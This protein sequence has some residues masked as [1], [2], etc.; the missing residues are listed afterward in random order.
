[1]AERVSMHLAGSKHVADLF[2]GCGTFAARLAATSS[3]TAVENDAPSLSALERGVRR[4]QGLKPVKTE[5][6]DLFRR[7]L[8]GNELRPFDG[9]V[10]DPPRAGAQ[11]QASELAKSNVARIAAVSCN[12]ATLARDLRLL[13]EGGY[14][15]V[16]V[17]PVDQ[18]LWAAHVE[19]VALL[20]RT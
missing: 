18:F 1:M 15:I 12:P 16:S 10:F 17:L 7:P 2:S 13:V 14:R 6:R 3:V 11:A 5:R 19:A 9:V 8:T 4:T 20:E